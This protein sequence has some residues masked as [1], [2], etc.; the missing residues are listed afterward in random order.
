ML[1]FSWVYLSSSSVYYTKA[2]MQRKAFWVA[3]YV[4]IFFWGGTVLTCLSHNPTCIKTVAS[5]VQPQAIFY[6]ISWNP[7]GNEFQWNSSRF[8]S[9]A[10]NISV[11]THY[12]YTHCIYTVSSDRRKIRSFVFEWV[13]FLSFWPEWTEFK[14]ETDLSGPQRFERVS[15]SE[16][17]QGQIMAITYKWR[18]LWEV[19]YL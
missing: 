15:T 18:L 14:N 7:Q 16:V 17:P 9:K 13:A 12:I 2:I 6:V 5:L 10:G 19:K 8:N 1:I 3:A 4:L 11:Y